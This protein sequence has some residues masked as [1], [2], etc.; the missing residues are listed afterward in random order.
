M[1]FFSEL[2]RRNV[3]K[4]AVSY[5]VVAWI[6]LQ[7][8][9]TTSPA[10]NIPE[11]VLSF[12][13]V[14]VLL[15]LPLALYISWAYEMTPDGL[16]PTAEVPV[17]E[18]I[19]AQTGRKMN[20][21]MVG[22]IGLLLVVV[23]VDAF[24]LEEVP[25][26]AIETV[27]A[28][29]ASAPAVESE[30]IPIPANSIAVLPFENLSSDQEQE[31]FSDGLTE[32]LL[33]QLAQV[34]GLQV[35][36]RTSSFAFKDR[37]ED[38][39]AIGETL[40]V[41][42]ILEGSVRKNGNELRITAQLVKAD[43]GYHLWSD[44]YDRELTDVFAI[45]DE[46]AEAVTTAL[47]ITIG[48]GDFG[49]PGMTRNI[50]AYDAYLQA[51]RGY[52][53]FSPTSVRRAIDQI[54]LA[55][56]LD[57]EFSRAWM[58]LTDIYG[59]SGQFIPQNQRTEFP[60]RIA[61]ARASIREVTPDLPELRLVEAQELI[62]DSQ[63]VDA[64]RVLLG[65]LDTTGASNAVAAAA[66]ANLLS[67]VGRRQE[68]LRYYQL[69]R[70]L[71]PLRVETSWFLMQAYMGLGRYQEASDEIERGLTLD[72][73]DQFITGQKMFMGFQRNDPEEARR[74]LDAVGQFIASSPTPNGT[75]LQDWQYSLADLWMQGDNVR[76][77]ELIRE[78]IR[79]PG[80]AGAAFTIASQW[81]TVLGD[82]QLALDLRN[83]KG[84]VADFIGERRDVSALWHPYASDMRKL[85]GFKEWLNELGVVNYWRSTG[86]W[87]DLCHPVN[88]DFECE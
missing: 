63:L 13:A 61:E 29:T 74:G 39:R 7:V 22:G 71:D 38:L 64:E 6:V 32:E 11:W 28:E 44:T 78:F 59:N 41:A 70:R 81:A 58:L 9:A 4:V 10:L 57:P 72:G 8:V 68:A 23:T 51:L 33:N 21:L 69:A 20:A 77:L 55:V 45:Q 18:S 25:P 82:P 66:Y 46:I 56:T 76:A 53:D 2:K 65:Y 12:V 26:A 30:T 43:D 42:H 84:E 85:P 80:R 16:K 35:A 24:V 17:E 50:D 31:Y 79:A 3:F 87:A 67:L 62:Q 15:G 52:H 88:D 60:A 27:A 34:N 48:A 19:R 73:M 1:S 75:L 40:G 5:A 49:L 86:N 47:S 54:E 14:L 37:N 83:G 36:G